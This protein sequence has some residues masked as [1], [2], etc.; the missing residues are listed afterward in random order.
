L[1]AVTFIISR[2]ESSCEP[3]YMRI[4]ATRTPPVAAAVRS[5]MK[6]NSAEPGETRP[7]STSTRFAPSG[8]E[9]P[10]MSVLRSSR[11]R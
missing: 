11:S 1:S 3:M 8:M 4:S 6:K 9:G 7:H 5:G 10:Q 2:L